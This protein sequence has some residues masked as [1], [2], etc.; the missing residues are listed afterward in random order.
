M[1]VWFVDFS[2]YIWKSAWN[3]HKVHACTRAC[4]YCKLDKI[5]STPL[6][7][8]AQRQNEVIDATRKIRP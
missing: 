3:R 1:N 8:F 2:I 6:P 7:Y 5:M 4:Y